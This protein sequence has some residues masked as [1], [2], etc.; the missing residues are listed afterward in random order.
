M[1][2]KEFLEKEGKKGQKSAPAVLFT[3]FLKELEERDKKEQKETQ[4]KLNSI[5]DKLSEKI[6]ALS[7]K[8]ETTEIKE[9]TETEIKLGI[10]LEK[11]SDKIDVINNSK[12]IFEARAEKVLRDKAIQK[13]DKLT[14][15]PPQQKIFYGGGGSGAENYMVDKQ[16]KK[17]NPATADNQ[18]I[19]ASY[20]ATD[21]DD[22]GSTKY[23]GFVRSNGAWYIMR[24]E[25]VSSI[26]QFRFASGTDNY[27][28]S[29]TNRATLSYDYIFNTVIH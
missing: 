11:L 10:L 25:V 24:E 18:D 5:L 22:T 27:V 2:F 13:I 23:Y 19:K 26:T 6:D 8:K 15:I 29:W 4:A 16:G 20:S 1:S 3:R 12:E 9:P 17:I 28:S 14:A 7:S 21:L